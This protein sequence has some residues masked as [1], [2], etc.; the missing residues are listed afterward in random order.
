MSEV[1]EWISNQG[2]HGIKLGGNQMKSTFKL[3]LTA[4]CLF[5]MMPTRALADETTKN[6]NVEKLISKISS[7]TNELENE[8][9][10][11]KAELKQ[12]KQ[13]Q[14][15]KIVQSPQRDKTLRFYPCR[16]KKSVT[17]TSQPNATLVTRDVYFAKGSPV[18][19]S[20]Y[21]GVRSE[22]DGSDLIVLNSGVN[23][24]VKLLNQKKTLLA[25]NERGHLPMPQTPTLVL[26]GRIEGQV[27]TG[28]NF[29][30]QAS[31]DINPAGAEL[32]LMPIVNSWV[33]GL[34]TFAYDNSMTAPRRINNSRVFVN[35]AFATVGNFSQSPF[36]ASI[37][38]MFL[39]FAGACSS[40][41]LTAP[42]PQQL[43]VVR[44]R[45][46]LVGYQPMSDNGFYGSLYVF[47]GPSNTNDSD[48]LNI[49]DGGVNLG[50]KAKGCRWSAELG[51]SYI[52]NIADAIGFQINGASSNVG[53]V[54]FGNT[55]ASEVLEHH[56]PG[57]DAHG[58]FKLDAYRLYLEYVSATKDFAEN[59]LSFNG[60]GAR[61]SSASI[62][63]AYLFD[64]CRR[65]SSVAVGYAR[66]WEAFALNLPRQRY[67]AV[68]NTSIW[69]DTMISLEYRYDLNYPRG[70]FGSGNG[71]FGLPVPFF[72]GEVM[73]QSGS[74]LTAQF[75][76]YF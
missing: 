10:L 24:D 3:G 29:Q 53:F 61:P 74:Q 66:T 46:L 55:N 65:P 62:E 73:N 40:F 37:G 60:D 33:T 45:A 71:A 72:P 11:L 54:G 64:I 25:L 68:F 30:N 6:D 17:Q 43:G 49:N 59:N 20:P 1:K 39:P 38:Q 57:M 50:L 47:N 9:K 75:G 7:R 13:K 76:I 26:S 31:S 63:G 12:L 18:I 67:S 27:S 23:R 5:A 32:D 34:I 42:L 21:L 19:T 44:D 41:M 8:I 2:S 16:D 58:S 51:A 69:K 70:T 15:K 35:D 52:G 14:A 48:R 28:K 22:F 36:Y 4:L 56:V